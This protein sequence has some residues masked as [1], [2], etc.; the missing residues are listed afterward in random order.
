M[1]LNIMYV[2]YLQGKFTILN[3]F[4]AGYYYIPENGYLNLLGGGNT[5]E[6][7]IT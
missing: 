6:G 2:I 7:N 5:R 4:K 3:L 1:V